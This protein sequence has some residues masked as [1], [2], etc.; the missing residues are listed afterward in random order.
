MNT[1]PFARTGLAMA[2]SLAFCAPVPAQD[3][4]KDTPAAMKMDHSKMHHHKTMMNQC[5][6]MME[7]MKAQDTA[8]T[9]Q[10]A[11]MNAAPKDEKLDLLAAIVTRMFDQRV[12]MNEKMGHM[13][14]EMMKH[15]EMGTMAPPPPAKK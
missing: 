14:M 2:L 4:P 5:K 8:L 11:K 10:I 13:H 9:A 15:M 6:G 7:E 1:N 3:S 12:A